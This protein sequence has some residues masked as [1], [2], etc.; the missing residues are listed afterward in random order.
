MKAMVLNQYGPE[1]AFEQADMPAPSA[2]SGQ[3]IVRVAA[4]SI[5]TVD[6]MI[7]QMG[8]DLPLS[9]DLPA[10]LG[11]DFAGTIEAVGE[12]VTGFAPGDEVYGCAGGLAD[13]QGALAELMPADA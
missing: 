9:P 3:V 10:V 4:T 13:L 7:R 11:M 12:G 6:T 1:A 8:K 2:L 5:N